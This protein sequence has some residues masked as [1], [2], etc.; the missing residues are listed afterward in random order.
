[1]ASALPSPIR[2][3]Q[4]FLWLLAVQILCSYWALRFGW[5]AV[6]LPLL[7]A[8]V[9]FSLFW[10]HFGL[11][12]LVASWFFPVPLSESSGVYPAD[13]I[14]FA[15]AG[16][17][18][19]QALAEGRSPVRHTPLNLWIFLWLGV[20][21]ISVGQ[22]SDFP[23]AIKNWFRH[24][25][26][27]LLFFTVV[28]CINAATVRR[29]LMLFIGLCLIFCAWNI[30]TFVRMGGAVRAFGPAH[31]LFSGFL[32]LAGTIAAAGTLF[33][34][35]GTQ[36]AS[37]GSALCMFVAGQM[38]NQS[39]GA[40]IQMVTGVIFVAWV[41]HRWSRCHHQ[42]QV[43]RRIAILAGVGAVG[44]I[45]LL[46]VASPLLSGVLARYATQ[47]S[48][49]LATAQ[50]RIFLWTS[51]LQM[52]LEH[53]LFGTGLAQMHAQADILPSMRFNPWFAHTQGLGFHNSVL[54]YLAETG[55]IGSIILLLLL[56]SA[57]RLGRGIISR[58]QNAPDAI[59][60]VGLWGVVFVIVMRYLYEGHLF[61]SISGMTTAAFFGF[62]FVTCASPACPSS[63]GLKASG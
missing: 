45:V 49:A 12:L 51:A 50:M 54:G 11:L 56:L 40:M 44:M 2:K 31:V 17:Y 19:L 5:V 46:L 59:W 14:L 61:Y 42:P 32:A 33:A 3:N 30:V 43:R 1:M 62:L 9:T 28:G 18:M 57:L 24:L 8:V 34:R 22:A 15:I 38:A 39:R 13:I 20:M 53:P 7:T 4:V 23:M 26:L 41:A 25:Q 36:R 16:G 6:F 60:P 63:R 37:W 35:R 10:P 47:D 27:F 55:I 52:F 48:S 29:A 21:L 58:T